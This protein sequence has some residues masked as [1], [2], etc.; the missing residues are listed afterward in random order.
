MANSRQ[1]SDAL[2]TQIDGLKKS[3]QQE[4]EMSREEFKKTLGVFSEAKEQ[5]DA[6]A[7]QKEESLNARQ[8]D[9][10]QRLTEMED[11]L[12][13]AEQVKAEQ[14]R[15]IQSLQ[16]QK[17]SIN[18]TNKQA[19]QD[20]RRETERALS[21]KERV[22]QQLVVQKRTFSDNLQR[23][24]DDFNADMKIFQE[25]KEKSDA[26]SNGTIEDLKGRL[27]LADD[28]FESTRNQ[29]ENLNLQLEETHRQNTSHKFKINNLQEE[30]ERQTARYEAD[31]QAMHNRLVKKTEQLLKVQEQSKIL[32]YKFTALERGQSAYMGYENRRGGGGGF[33]PSSPAL[34]PLSSAASDGDY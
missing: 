7:R 27:A 22:S 8:A 6:A 19:V 18:E 15:R 33:A 26:S 24:Q 3:H 14:E 2:N 23:T 21:D 4:L 25:A 31:N 16:L 12:E 13:R 5:A 32:Q 11:E 28:E 1:R 9:I 30:S 29:I 20:A 10:E 34:A 17:D